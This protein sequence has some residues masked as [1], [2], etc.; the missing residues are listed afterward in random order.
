MLQCHW[1]VQ[2]S[3]E[4]QPLKRFTGNV[5][6]AFGRERDKR[7]GDAD[8]V[9]DSVE[10]VCCPVQNHNDLLDLRRPDGNIKTGRK[11]KLVTHWRMASSV[12]LRTLKADSSVAT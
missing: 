3:R 7:G 2:R 11:P 12:R 8:V 10:T 4:H 5:F 9:T 6:N 1:V